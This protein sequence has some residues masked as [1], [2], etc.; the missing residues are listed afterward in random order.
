MRDIEE[1]LMKYNPK[2][3]L[4]PDDIDLIEKSLRVMMQYGNKEECRELLAKIHHQKIWYRPKGEIYVS[5]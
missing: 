2:F 4:N 3:K 1:K 5:G